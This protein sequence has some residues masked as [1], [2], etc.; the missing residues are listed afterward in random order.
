MIPFNY[1]SGSAKANVPVPV[2]QYCQ[3]PKNDVYLNSFSY[4]EP[5]G[6]I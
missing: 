6:E 5:K 1:G 2:P 4:L 3:E